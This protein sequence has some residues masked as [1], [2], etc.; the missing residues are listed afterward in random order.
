MPEQNPERDDGPCRSGPLPDAVVD[1]LLAALDDEFQAEATYRAVI[2]RFGRVMPFAV[3]LG[4][5]QRHAAAVI[6]LLH[7]YGRAAPAN[8]YQWSPDQ[9]P[10]SLAAACDAAVAA[11]VKNA[12]LYDHALLPVVRDYPDIEA[13]FLRLR[14]A[15]SHCHLPAFRHWAEIYRSEGAQ[16]ET[17]GEP[18]RGGGDGC[19]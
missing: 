3:I 12:A 2:G 15:S 14:D 9:I 13:V 7:R 11:E 6:R 17:T 10:D 4:A 18:C 16:R 1:A 8:P 19:C 5:E